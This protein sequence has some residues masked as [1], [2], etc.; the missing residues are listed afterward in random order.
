MK[1][2]R[3]YTGRFRQPHSH[4]HNP[5]RYN[6]C[7]YRSPAARRQDTGMRLRRYNSHQHMSQ[8]RP[9]IRFGSRCRLR[10][11][12]SCLRRRMIGM[13]R[14]SRFLGCMRC[15]RRYSLC[16]WVRR[17]LRRC[18]GRSGSY[19]R[20]R[21]PRRNMKQQSRSIGY[22]PLCMRLRH[23]IHHSCLCRR[24]TGLNLQ[25]HLHRYM[26]SRYSICM[27]RNSAVR[28]QGI[29]MRPHHHMQTRH[30]PQTHPGIRFSCLRRL[31]GL[32]TG[33]CCISGIR[34]IGHLLCIA[35]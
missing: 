19:T 17:M 12:C 28:R 13:F 29:G 21:S 35:L 30:R 25:R 16:R 9:D 18:R 2:R 8:T 32:Y 1:R 34:R 33:S 5:N 3:H 14:R 20:S 10:C 23:Y 26:M 27:C 7:M 24:Y 4:R 15:F 6:T 31:F 11:L 22:Y